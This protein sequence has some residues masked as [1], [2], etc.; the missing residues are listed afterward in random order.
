[1]G[2]DE[3]STLRDKI[4]RAKDS[5]KVP[6]VIAGNKCD[7]S[8]QRKVSRKN[9]EDLAKQ[10]G[11]PFFETSAKDKIHNEEC[12]YEVVRQI[13]KFDEEKS[14]KSKKSKKKN[15]LCTLL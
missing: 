14:A 3:S 8:E 11:C 4:I 13:R 7:L 15:K 2:F 9:A 6:I 1:M 10:W 5:D 12:F